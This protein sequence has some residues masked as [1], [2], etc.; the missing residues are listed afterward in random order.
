MKKYTSTRRHTTLLRN[1]S[2]NPADRGAPAFSRASEVSM[3]SRS[4][5]LTQ[6]A[7][8]GRSAT[9]HH[10]SGA[11]IRNGKMPSMKNRVR[12]SLQVRIQPDSGAVMIE[13]M[14]MFIIQNP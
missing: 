3:Y 6:E 8:D 10:H 1:T 4:S 2:C 12:Q 14:A 9:S 11:A 7:C 5:R 13:A